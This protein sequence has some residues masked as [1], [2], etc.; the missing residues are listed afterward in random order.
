MLYTLKYYSSLPEQAKQIRQE[1]FVDEQGF[2]EEFDDADDIAVH[3]LLFVDGQAAATCRTFYDAE[4]GC[5]VVGRIAVRKDY[6]GQQLGAAVLHGAEVYIAQ[7]GGE[8]VMLAAQERAHGFYEKQGYTGT[9]EPFYEE[10]C[11]HIW[12][13]KEL[14][15]SKES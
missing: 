7:H 11:P 4:Q 14:S 10:Y 9:G 5:P 12:M 8:K 13:Q 15:F 1:V 2:Q 6:R 3:F